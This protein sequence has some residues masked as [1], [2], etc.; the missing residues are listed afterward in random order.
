MKPAATC[1]AHTTWTAVGLGEQTQAVLA[2]LATCSAGASRGSRVLSPTHPINQIFSATLS[3]P[4]TNPQTLDQDTLKT[5][6][7]LGLTLRNCG[8]SL[9]VGCGWLLVSG[10]SEFWWASGCGFRAIKSLSG[11]GASPVSPVRLL[12]IEHAIRLPKAPLGSN[13][14]SSRYSKT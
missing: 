9:R 12:L 8:R 13:V 3:K 4:Q 5:R 1:W 10:L 7:N 6:C 14:P 2:W 11:T